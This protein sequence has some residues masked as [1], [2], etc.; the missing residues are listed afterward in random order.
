LE[1]QN[2]HSTYYQT[3]EALR[4]IKWALMRQADNNPYFLEKNLADLNHTIKKDAKILRTINSQLKG[5]R[6]DLV[7]LFESYWQSYRNILF[8]IAIDMYFDDVLCPKVASFLR[9]NLAKQKRLGRYHEYFSALTAPTLLTRSQKEERDFFNILLQPKGKRRSLFKEHLSAYAYIPMWF[10]NAPWHIQDME[11]RARIY[12]TK[13]VIRAHLANL[14]NRE[15]KRNLITKEVLDNFHPSQEMRTTIRN[16]Q[17]FAYLRHE[18]ELQ[19]S[20]HNFLGLPLMERIAHE[21]NL[22]LSSL[23]FL[24]DKEIVE[25]LKKKKYGLKKLVATRAK[26]CFMVIKD[27]TYS[28]AVGKEG[29]QLAYSIKNKVIEERFDNTPILKGVVGS[30]GSAKGKV[31]IIRDLHEIA[32]FQAGEVLV[33]SGTSVEYLSV[34]HRA[35]AIVSEMGG[36]TSHAAVIARELGKPCLTRVARATE[37]LKNGEEVEV[38]AYVGTIKRLSKTNFSRVIFP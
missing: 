24:T 32:G 8:G 6:V 35:A 20:Y 1:F 34:M 13:K 26:Y 16:V 11:R 38:D 30:V 15:K 7:G 17:R 23:K 18:G 37:I 10:D 14:K 3:E 21:L 9:S 29:K 22:P 12:P 27:G 25:N 28:V 19:I 2:G 36:I 5:R 31:R 33:V 4:E